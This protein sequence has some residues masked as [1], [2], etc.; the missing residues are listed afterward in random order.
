MLEVWEREGGGSDVREREGSGGID[1][2]NG[3]G[4]GEG[5]ATIVR[6]RVPLEGD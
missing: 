3:V 5:G 4:E 2:D 1:E 6:G